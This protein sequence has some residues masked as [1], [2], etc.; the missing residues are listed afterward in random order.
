MQLQALGPVSLGVLPLLDGDEKKKKKLLQAL[1]AHHLAEKRRR[2]PKQEFL[3]IRT[4]QFCSCFQI[5]MGNE[6]DLQHLPCVYLAFLV[7]PFSSLVSAALIKFIFF[8]LPHLHKHNL[9]CL[10][11]WCLEM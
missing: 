8:P 1:F 4:A 3:Q 10:E 7:V 9:C 11:P 2:S 5:P 6:Y